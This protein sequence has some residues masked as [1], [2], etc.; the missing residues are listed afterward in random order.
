MNLQPRY[1][2]CPFCGNR[3]S[4]SKNKIFCERCNRT[5]YQHTPQTA[6]V[7]YENDENKVL[8]VQRKHEPFRNKWS[9]PAGFVEYGEIPI[10]TGL[11]ELKEETGLTAAF[12]KI[13]G[14]YMTYDHPATTSL[15]TVISVKNVTGEI[16]SFDDT[17]DAK[18]FDMEELPILAF[19]AHLVA[20]KD[21]R[22]GFL[23]IDK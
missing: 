12:E 17:K 8:L 15:L 4:P 2:F 3:V 21:F 10:Q 1:S 9:L 23:R 22:N 19:K 5:F 14:F 16:K 13:I 11:R 18:F 20:I 7:I 6:A